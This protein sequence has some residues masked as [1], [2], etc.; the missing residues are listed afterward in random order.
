[1]KSLLY[2]CHFSFEIYVFNIERCRCECWVCFHIVEGWLIL[3]LEKWAE[4]Q[5]TASFY[6]GLLSDKDRQ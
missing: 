2:L 5:L 3:R 4:L 1:M 6:V